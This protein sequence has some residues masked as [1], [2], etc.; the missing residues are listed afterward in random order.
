MHED[1]ALHGGCPAADVAVEETG[2]VN[3]DLHKRRGIAAV[4]VL[5]MWVKTFYWMRLF[6]PT[7][8]YIRLIG[9]TLRDIKYFLILFIFILMT[10]GNTL[11]IMN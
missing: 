4:L 5:L 2:V 8:F 10:F 7:S 11:L 1:P 9:E 3:P 6:S